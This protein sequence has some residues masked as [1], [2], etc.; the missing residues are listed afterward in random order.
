MVVENGTIY[1]TLSDAIYITYDS[2]ETIT[3]HG[4]GTWII[5]ISSGV[6]RST[7]TRYKTQQKY[8][9]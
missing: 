1:I 8:T 3:L 6:S 4:G 5:G 2:D 7:I 9:K